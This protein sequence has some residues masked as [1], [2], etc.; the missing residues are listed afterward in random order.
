[1]KK[2]LIAFIR[3]PFYS[4]LVLLVMLLGGVYSLSQ[5][6]KSFFPE[7]T[8]RNIF[9]TVA[10]PGASPKEMEEGITVRIEEAVRGLVG[11]KEINSTS[12]ENFARVQITTTGE[13]DIDVTLQE[14]KNAV[15]GI[16][17]MPVS[18]ERPIV[19]KQRTTT[20]AINMALAGDDV[21][22]LT[23][24]RYAM[25]IEDDFR[26]T[27]LMSQISMS[28]YPALELSVEISEENLLRYQLTFD[29]V[30][31]AIAQNNS[32]ISAGQ[33][34]STKE[35]ILIRSRK[36][37]VD[38]AEIANIIIRANADGSALRIS[39]VGTV[40]LQFADVASKSLLN[41]QN[42][43]GFFIQ[44][45]IVEDLKEISDYVNRYVAEF[46]MTHEGVRLYITFD[47]LRLLKARLLILYKNGGAGLILVILTLGLFLSMR[48]SFWVAFGIPASFAGMF[49]V[50]NIFGITINMISLFGMILVVGILVD[51]GIVIAENIYS[52]FER[53][54]TPR[55]AAVDGAMEVLPAVLT[56]VSTTIIAFLPLFLIKE[57]GMEFMY[58][59]AFVVVF[60]LLFSLIEAFLIL[61]GH[62]G[63]SYIL[64]SKERQDVW[65]TIRRGLDKAI[66]YIRDRVYGGILKFIIKL[67]WIMAGIVPIILIFI[68]V[69]LFKQGKIQ[70][71]FFPVIPFDFFNIDLAFTPGSGEEKT[72]AYLQKFEEVVW[73]VNHELMEEYGNKISELKD[74]SD[75]V[76]Y[77]FL[78]IGSAFDGV[79]TGSH[80][81]SIFVML[82]DLDKT[83]ISSFD[84][85]NRIRDKIGPVPEAE[86]FT[87]GGSNRFGR[88]VAISLLGK[89]LDELKKAEEM[90]MSSMKDMD[91]ISNVVQT[92]AAGK[93]EV[94]IDLKPKAYFLGLDHASI[95][96]QVRQG[97]FGG[98][99]Q[100]LQEGKDELR[101]W[102]RYP[103]GGRINLGQMED[104]R[105]KTP[106]GEYPLSELVDY[107]IERGPVN[108]KRYN[109]SREI[110]VEADLTD[111]YAA[112]PPIL[113]KIKK[114]ALKEIEAKYPGIRVE[115]QGQQRSSNEATGELKKLYILAIII[116][117]IIIMIHFKSLG[118]SLI[119]LLMIPLSWLGAAWGHGFEGIPVSM[120]S[121]WG[122][123]A[124]S[125]VIINDAVVFLSKYNLNLREG[126]T[127]RQ[128]VLEAG[129]SRF[130]PILLTTITTT[131]GL[132]P[133]ILET[134]FQAQFL[135][136]MAVSLAY[137][138]LIGTSFILLFFPALVM[139][140]NDIRVWANWLWTGNKPSAESV[141]KAIKYQI[142][143]Q[144]KLD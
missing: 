25:E 77:S 4:N 99:A 97:F 130:R 141:E 114:G 30:I 94:L 38:P 29:E 63:H 136:P 36:R 8:S 23:L 32:D 110:R 15:D 105:I 89:D 40:K 26:F 98:Q 85:A 83:G 125:G 71:T 92:N 60:S 128:A 84:V 42:A 139:V 50:A 33:I 81:G 112:V 68:T 75:F 82:R 107:R 137:G 76:K 119:I 80:A 58:E 52:H 49:I 57:G 121:A 3:Y 67:R 64:R 28:G 106:L 44:K 118:Q 135:I 69:V 96:N 5:M 48:L 24:K 95:S 120:L 54:K 101:V 133:L 10:Y 122:M 72:M 47:F 46:N 87:V 143:E 39:D 66:V 138:V 108:I 65:M 88:P 22:L 124:L 59:M 12:S 103:K 37:S 116:I 109:M 79:E 34:K 70:A 104:M 43:V 102:V 62:L 17:S 117:A 127:V 115:F 131:V 53:G 14:V 7:R 126:L 91:E 41:D 113:E 16:S 78:G 129:T 27:G 21:D 142:R 144:V 111:P 1:M 19:F 20:P 9:V 55:K 93:R 11:I 13:Y 132:Y 31:R 73:E 6:K 134:S 123:V 61:P 45:L 86:K 51:D 2:L 56:S 35:E 90:L 100:R 74:T 18:A 140:S